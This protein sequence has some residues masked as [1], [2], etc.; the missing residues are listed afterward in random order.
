MSF[1][2]EYFTL[3]PTDSTNEYISLGGTPI[4]SDNVALDL[5]GGTAQALSG[6]FAVDSTSVRWDNTSYNLNGQLVTGDKLRVI[7]DKS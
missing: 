7:Y 5:I 3:T 4:V 2:V 6:D 1:E